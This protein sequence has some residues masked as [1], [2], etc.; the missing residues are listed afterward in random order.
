[1]ITKD[2]SITAVVLI[3]GLG[4]AGCQSSPEPETTTEE[5]T[6]YVKKPPVTG[7][8]LTTWIDNDAIMPNTKYLVKEDGKLFMKAIYTKT[9]YADAS[10][11]IEELTETTFNGLVRYNYSNDHGEYYLIENS[12]S[13]GIYDS[14]GKFKELRKQ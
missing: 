10:V 5:P 14:D 3:I 12:G 6:T 7:E 2:L 13:L 11:I 1:M 4:L 9:Q 8:V